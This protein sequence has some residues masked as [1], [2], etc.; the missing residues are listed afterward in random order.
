MANSY[1]ILIRLLSF[2]LYLSHLVVADGTIKRRVVVKSHPLAV[3][4]D[5]QARSSSVKQVQL[6]HCTDTIR[7]LDY[8]LKPNEDRT[9]Y[10]KRALKANLNMHL[11]GTFDGHGGFSASQFVSRHLGF[12]LQ[13]KLNETVANYGVDRLLWLIDK[14]EVLP[15]DIVPLIKRTLNE[16]VEE[17]DSVLCEQFCMRNTGSTGSFT[18]RIRDVAFV[19]NIGDSRT[20]VL[21]NGKL[22]FRTRDHLPI[23]PTELMHINNAGGKVV[24]R[25]NVYR[26]NGVLAM[27][28]AF[29]DCMCKVRGWETFL[30]TSTCDNYDGTNGIMRVTPDI[31]S[32]RLHLANSTYSFFSAT[33]GLF[34]VYDDAEVADRLVRPG[35]ASEKP[36]ICTRLVHNARRIGSMDDITSIFVQISPV[37]KQSKPSSINT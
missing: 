35:I 20:L 3:H 37:G 12:A 5:H 26:L 14:F 22:L 19:V 2:L 4:A 25:S 28:R 34:D 15:D 13:H 32:I 11:F 8:N 18:L 31:T 17:I 27:S 9:I 24:F 16:T 29:G 23:D 33:D 7:N 30:E 1:I 21:E 10:E 36:S 6:Y